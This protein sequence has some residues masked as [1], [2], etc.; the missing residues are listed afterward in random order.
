VNREEQRQND[1]QREAGSE[2]ASQRFRRMA[3][4]K[5]GGI[6]VDAPWLKRDE[7]LTRI[8]QAA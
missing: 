8:S 7:R 4:N 1:E 3:Q 5:K 2:M 6:L